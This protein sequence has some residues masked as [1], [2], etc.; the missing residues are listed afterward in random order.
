MLWVALGGKSY[1]REH[2][3]RL[4]L[5][6]NFMFRID[7]LAYKMKHA[8]F[9][10]GWDKLIESASVILMLFSVSIPSL[11]AVVEVPLWSRT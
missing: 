8:K 7:L 11:F 4:T 9:L 1:L 5:R 3:N 6:H 10:A 2:L